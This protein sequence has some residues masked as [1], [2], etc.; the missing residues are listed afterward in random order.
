M[1]KSYFNSSLLEI[2]SVSLFYCCNKC[3]DDLCFVF[4]HLNILSGFD[5]IR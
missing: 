1:I 3:F 4:V 5:E 2:S